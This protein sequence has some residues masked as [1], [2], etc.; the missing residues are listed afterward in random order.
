MY[1]F[2]FTLYLSIFSPLQVKNKP[3]NGDLEQV[4]ILG[5]LRSVVGNNKFHRYILCLNELA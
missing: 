1:V 3:N 4:F 5:P 2:Y